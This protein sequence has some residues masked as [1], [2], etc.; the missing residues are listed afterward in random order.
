MKKEGG[1]ETASDTEKGRAK[2]MS[3]EEMDGR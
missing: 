3:G 1:V 2:G